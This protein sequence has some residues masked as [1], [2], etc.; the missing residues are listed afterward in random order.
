MQN[1]LDYNKVQLA[2]RFAAE[3][4]PKYRADQLFTEIFQN[5]KFDFDEMTALPKDFRASLKEIFTIFDI[6]EHKYFVSEDTTEKLLIEFNNGKAIECVL[7]PN[8][9]SINKNEDSRTL[10]IS[11]QEGCKLNCKFCATGKLGFISNLSPSEIITQI[12]FAEHI[13]GKKISNIVLMGMGDPLDN[14]ESV[15]KA[16]SIVITEQKLFGKNRITLSTAG[17]TEN[18]DRLVESGLNIKLAFS[19]HSAIQKN[20]EEIMPSAKKWKIH[21]I[22]KT[23]E[24]YYLTTKQVI[25]FE[26]IV[27]DGFNNKDEDVAAIRK[28]CSHFPCKINLIQ[29]HNIDFTG[30]KSDLL[31]ASFQQILEFQA[32]LKKSGV[33]TF[34]RKSAGSDI[35]AACG[36]L[37]YGGKK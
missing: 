10:C 30:F 23:L 31:P 20:R 7:I 32:K 27:F 33:D 21:E 22:V 35:A 4:L 8:N 18:I 17:F 12:L 29:Y 16:L 13:S 26:Y 6:K 37:A 19:L 3:G 11:T 1:I 14:Y 24:K 36:Q 2:A 9:N 34:V 28:V 25:T 15:S 5:R